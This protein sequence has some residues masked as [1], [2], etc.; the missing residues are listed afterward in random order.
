[1]NHSQ[2]PQTPKAYLERPVLRVKFLDDHGE[3]QQITVKSTLALGLEQLE[4]LSQAIQAWMGAVD[5]TMVSIEAVNSSYS[6]LGE[7]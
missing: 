2:A 4:R 5:W 7:T 6:E 3:P 1:M